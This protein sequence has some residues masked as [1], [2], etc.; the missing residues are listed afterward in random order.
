MDIVVSCREWVQTQYS[1]VSSVWLSRHVNPIAVIL[2]LLGLYFAY[3]LIYGFFLCPSRHIPGPLLTRFGK[4]YYY[5]VLFGGSVSADI[6]KLHIKYGNCFT[7]PPAKSRSR[8]KT[9]S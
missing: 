7:V 3:V 4:W 5:R 1:N 9:G 2:G 8:S 6:H